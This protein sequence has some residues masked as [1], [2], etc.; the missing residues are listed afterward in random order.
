MRGAFYSV[1]A[2]IIMGILIFT[3][4]IPLR[5]Y[6]RFVKKNKA[7][8]K[9]RAL[10]TSTVN[11]IFF[12]VLFF[13][14]FVVYLLSISFI[15]LPIILSVLCFAVSYSH[16]IKEKP[17]VEDE[18]NNINDIIPVDEAYERIIDISNTFNLAVRG[19]F[20]VDIKSIPKLISEMERQLEKVKEY[21]KANAQNLISE[22]ILDSMTLQ[23]EKDISSLR[24]NTMLEQMKKENK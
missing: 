20:E 19:Q 23:G 12:F 4:T 5:I 7:Y 16:L 14:P 2:T 3:F 1:L 6:N 21:N 24:N 9:K 10:L 15:V 11:A 17:K 22:G 18:A 13:V 8:T